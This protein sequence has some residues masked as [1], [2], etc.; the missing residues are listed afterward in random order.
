MNFL[1]GYVTKLIANKKQISNYNHIKLSADFLRKSDIKWK[2]FL[3]IV[4]VAA[5]SC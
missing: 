4:W 3:L 1:F 5:F 2:D